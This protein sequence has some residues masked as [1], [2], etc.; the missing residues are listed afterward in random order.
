M[1]VRGASVFAFVLC[2]LAIASNLDLVFATNQDQPTKAASICHDDV[3]DDGEFCGHDAF[4]TTGFPDLNHD[5][6]IDGLDIA[7]FLVQHN[8]TGPNLSADLNGD[9][10]VHASDFEFF[11]TVGRQVSPCNITPVTGS[12]GG[13]I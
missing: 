4:S 13:T 9:G 2:I 10:I 5:C 12:C 3:W 1:S 7:L 6:L 11:S 8:A